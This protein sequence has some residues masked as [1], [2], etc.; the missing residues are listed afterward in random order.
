MMLSICSSGRKVAF[1]WQQKGMKPWK[2]Q[3][4]FDPE[5]QGA[6]SSFLKGLWQDGGLGKE[7]MAPAKSCKELTVSTKGRR[8][9][10]PLH[11]LGSAGG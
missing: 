8:N 4:S 6:P 7:K 9:G 5:P 10:P 2:P 3:G 1:E 11:Q